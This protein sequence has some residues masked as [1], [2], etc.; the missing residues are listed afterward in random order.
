MPPTFTGERPG[1]AAGFAYDVARHLAAYLYARELATEGRLDDA[2]TALDGLAAAYPGDARIALLAGEVATWRGFPGEGLAWLRRAA[3]SAPGD[4]EP[5]LRAAYVLL[6]H[7]PGGAPDVAAALAEAA[8]ALAD[9]G[10]V[11]SA[12]YRACRGE[13]AFAADDRE[14]AEAWF[15]GVLELQPR[16][17]WALQR[18]LQLTAALGAAAD[19]E[20]ADLNARLSAVIGSGEMGHGMEN[21]R[22]PPT[23]C[24]H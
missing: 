16:C 12:A 19:P 10:G 21:A 6:V 5:H 7:P 17:R 1:R 2:R 20:R 23:F 14:A 8:L 11:E 4:P 18:L 3:E 9:A 22:V 15:R 24:G 13:A